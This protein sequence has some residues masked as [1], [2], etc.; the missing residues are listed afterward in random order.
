MDCLSDTSDT[1]ATSYERG[2]KA[3]DVKR[4]VLL[5][6]YPKI[7]IF[8][9]RTEIDQLT[10][11]GYG[12]TQEPAVFGLNWNIDQINDYIYSL[13]PDVP[14]QT[15]GFK[16]GKCDR[17]KKVFILKRVENTKELKEELGNSKLIIIPNEELPERP[18]I[19][20]KEDDSDDENTTLTRRSERKSLHKYKLSEDDEDYEVIIENGQSSKLKDINE[21]T[22]DH[23]EYSVEKILDKRTLN[24]KVEYLLKWKGYSEQDN[25]WE[26]EENLD[27][28]DLIAAY[29]AQFE[30]IPKV[31]PEENEKVNKRKNITE[32]NRARGFDR[33]LEPDK[34]VGATDASGELMFLMM[35]KN[36][37]E[38]DL[39]PASQVNVRCPEVVINYY[40]NKEQWFCKQSIIEID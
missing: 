15:I 17:T 30:V 38:A 32:D 21:E 8:P 4:P 19:H 29:E 35:W 23:E 11:M 39:V 1:S 36:C 34:I 3:M 28:P 26:P 33:G 31:D 7:E 5:I 13:Y 37:K 12:F 24:G 10:A 27:C 16:M 2:R 20:K 14:L 6:R 40:E 22:N 18:I 9:S 25:T